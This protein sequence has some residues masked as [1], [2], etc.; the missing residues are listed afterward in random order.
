MRLTGIVCTNTRNHRKTFRE[1]F[2]KR[3]KQKP[4]KNQKN[5]KYR[6]T[7]GALFTLSLPGGAART[8][9][10]PSVTP[11]RG[12]YTNSGSRSPALTP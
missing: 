9:T 12:V 6:N 11:L 8:P 5:T 4:T 1:I 2:E 10:P 7:G 3:S